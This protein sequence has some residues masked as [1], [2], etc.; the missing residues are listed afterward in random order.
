MA[1]VNLEGKPKHFPI[2]LLRLMIVAISISEV[3]DRGLFWKVVIYE[4]FKD[5][6]TITSCSHDNAFYIPICD[7]LP[8]HAMHFLAL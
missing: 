3:A 6:V 5:K 8:C 7:N 4:L 2:I 1:L